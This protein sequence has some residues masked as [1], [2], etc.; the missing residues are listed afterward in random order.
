MK[1]QMRLGVFSQLMSERRISVLWGLGRIVT[2]VKK[3]VA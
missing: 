1:E 3:A 2:R